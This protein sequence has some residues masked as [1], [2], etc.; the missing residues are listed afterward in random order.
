MVPPSRLTDRSVGW[1]ITEGTTVELSSS[2]STT[3]I[4]TNRFETIRGMGV[5]S[6]DWLKSLI[7]GRL[8][9]YLDESPGRVIHS[10]KSKG[11]SA[12]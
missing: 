7:Q 3:F 12:G 4:D 2:N 1:H 8:I 5:A 11:A 6:N 9:A 10:P